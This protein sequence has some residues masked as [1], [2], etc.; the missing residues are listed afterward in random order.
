VAE[1]GA[2]DASKCGITAIP[3]MVLWEGWTVEYGG[4]LR[5]D[6]LADEFDGKSRDGY[7]GAKSIGF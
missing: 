3:E 6:T 4:A 2:G 5:R 7:N 1:V